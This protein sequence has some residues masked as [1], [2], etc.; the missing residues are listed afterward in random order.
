VAVNA[1]EVADSGGLHRRSAVLLG[2]ASRL[3][4]A[5]DHTD[6]QVHDLTDRAKAAL[7]DD[8]FAAAYRRGWELDA[9]A[10]MTE[11]DPGRPHLAGM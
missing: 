3:R 1:A 7:G 2:A 9:K 8:A 6:Q 5:H 11:V 10:A 4:G